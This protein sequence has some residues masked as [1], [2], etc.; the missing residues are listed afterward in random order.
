MQA[1]RLCVNATLN[2][3]ADAKIDSRFGK[4]TIHSPAVIAIAG[5]SEVK[6][7]MP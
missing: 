7:W 5:R 1:P 3:W 2:I 4:F 6:P